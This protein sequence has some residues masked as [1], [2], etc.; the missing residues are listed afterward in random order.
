MHDDTSAEVGLKG[1]SVTPVD[2][3]V[4]F[5]IT[6]TITGIAYAIALR[7]TGIFLK[8]IGCVGAVI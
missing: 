7:R 5:K 1:G 6:F 3:A 8:G 2:I 4:T